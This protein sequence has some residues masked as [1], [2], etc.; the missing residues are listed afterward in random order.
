MGSATRE[1]LRASEFRGMELK[2]IN[3]PNRTIKNRE[4]RL[5]REAAKVGYRIEK[6]RSRNPRSV[7]YGGYMLIDDK[8]NA[9]VIGGHPFAYNATLDDIE[10]WLGA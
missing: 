2:M 6:S 7:E 8:M 3:H 10:T 9:V 1:L 4:D 5:R